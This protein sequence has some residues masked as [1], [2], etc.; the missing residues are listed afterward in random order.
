[1]L[2]TDELIRMK[3]NEFLSSAAEAEMLPSSWNPFCLFTASG[4]H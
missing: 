2:Q 4:K 3:W 1:M